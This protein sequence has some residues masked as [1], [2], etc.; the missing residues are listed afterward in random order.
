MQE[1]AKIFQNGGS[2]AVRL[3]KAYWFPEG[4]SDG[5]VRRVEQRIVLEVADEW[6]SYF[7]NALGTW[8]EDIPRPKQRRP[9]TR[10]KPVAVN[11][12]LDSVRCALRGDGNAEA[13]IMETKASHLAVSAL[14]AAELRYGADRIRRR[15]RADV[16][17]HRKPAGRAWHPDRRIRCAYRGPCARGHVHPIHQQRL[18][19]S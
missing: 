2:Q 10:K 7:L 15:C 11:Y 5:V 18:A 12:F 8:T 17:S 14:T 19:F 16:R 1:R 6:P 3:P 9:G 4:Q 13:R